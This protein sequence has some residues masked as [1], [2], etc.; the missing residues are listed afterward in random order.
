MSGLIHFPS[1]PFLSFSHF[2]TGVSQISI[3]NSDH[4]SHNKTPVAVWHIMDIALQ[5]GNLSE[6]VLTTTIILNAPVRHING[7]MKS[8]KSLPISYTIASTSWVYFQTWMAVCI[9]SLQ[10]K[11]FFVIDRIQVFIRLILL[12]QFTILH[13]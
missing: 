4:S 8:W 1:P 11:S 9:A 13:N 7:N 10:C 6:F 3:F 5:L 12:Q 2:L